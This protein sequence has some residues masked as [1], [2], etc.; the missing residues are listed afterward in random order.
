MEAA[1]RDEGKKSGGIGRMEKKMRMR[2]RMRMRK[3]AWEEYN[4]D[5]VGG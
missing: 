2:M 3:E 1:G 5:K 4:K